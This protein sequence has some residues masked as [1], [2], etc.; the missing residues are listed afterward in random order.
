MPKQRDSK[1][2]DLM[3]IMQE[4]AKRIR[5]RVREA[6]ISGV[7]N[8]ELL[9]I[10]EEKIGDNRRDVYRPALTSF[11]CEAVGGQPAEADEAA[12][13][14]TLASAGFGVHDDIIDHSH[15]KHFKMT[16]LGEYGLESALLVGD[17][18]IVKAWT[19]IHEMIGNAYSTTKIEAI[20]KEYGRLNVEIC[21]A[22][23]MGFLYR[24]NLDIKW[25]TA[26]NILWKAMAEMEACTRIG[27]ILG[28]GSQEEVEVL[29]EFG[30]RLGF[31]YRLA[32][33]LK[34]T[35]DKEGNLP[36]RLRH[37][38]IPLPLLFA[39]KSSKQRYHRI[40]S[41][42]QKSLIGDEDV[43]ELREIC[44]ESEAVEKVLDLAKKNKKK[45][46]QKL[47]YLRPSPA[48]DVLSRMNCHSLECVA[49]FVL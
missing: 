48:R 6:V 4:R 5:E 44:I 10:L 47:T 35:R 7:S 22:E 31:T 30:R 37:E 39:A 13:M 38:S 15:N 17:L 36:Y 25:K 32:D 34:D 45:A 8:P 2:L 16:I 3:P 46:E 11:S 40:Q 24:R 49:D 18:L 21:E 42:I 12:L 20:V 1:E 9:S 41:I 28:N 29:A 19:V 14:F 43:K 33:E 23:F 26:K 27:G